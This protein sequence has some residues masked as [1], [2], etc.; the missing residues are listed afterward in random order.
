MLTTE[1]KI[2]LVHK[3]LIRNIPAASLAKEFRISQQYVSFLV[4]K[5]RKNPKFYE[6]MRSDRDTEEEFTERVGQ[7]VKEYLKS[8]I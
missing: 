1:E 3:Y 4:V 7:A 6:E 5:A 2:D 8:D